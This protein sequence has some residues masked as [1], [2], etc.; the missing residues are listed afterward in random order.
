LRVRVDNLQVRVT[1]LPF[2]APEAEPLLKPHI[3]T[4]CGIPEKDI[5]DYEVAAKSIDGRRKPPS[6][7]YSLHVELTNGASPHFAKVPEPEPFRMPENQ[8]R[9]THPIVVGSGPA[10]LL[11]G[12]LL[13][14][15]GCRPLILDRGFDV[16]TRAADIARFR[17]GRVLN[18]ESNYLLGEG[19]AGTFSDGKLYTRTRDPNIRLVLETFVRCGAPPEILY[20]KRPHIGSDRLPGMI[21]GIRREIEEMGG[22]FRFGCGVRSILMRG[23]RCTGVI[24]LSGEEIE[25]PAVLVGH[26]LGGRDLTRELVRMG[27]EMQLKGFQVGCR[28][29]HPQE[30]I[31]RNQFGL[32]K[33][34][35]FLGAAEYNF[36]SHPPNRKGISTFCMCPGGEIVP[37][38][39]FP[40]RLSTNGMSPYHRDGEFANSCLI[41]TMEPDG[42]ATPEQAF[43]FL[44]GL[45]TR[46]FELGGGDYTAPAQSAAGF[47][48]GEAKLTGAGTS[49]CFGLKAAPLNQLFPKQ[50]SAALSAALL[51]FEKICPGFM[52]RGTLV[53]VETYVSSPVRF[54]RNEHGESSLPGLFL[55]GEGAGAAGGIMSAAADG[56]KVATGMLT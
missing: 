16:A 26:G 28:I 27:L 33:R 22:T 2:D 11:A 19:G 13:A 50:E 4:F 38:T 15:A 39:T 40:G 56:L 14:A 6:L 36:V 17:A 10:G 7:I 18:P 3:A 5:L 21:A 51:H 45:E 8:N 35:A 30:L 32:R 25:A 31:D 23:G 12:W 52:N 48:R 37:S 44:A 29:E 41:S 55:A 24:T 43:E 46:A 20:L 34:P 47:V 53:G 9:L 1:D 49:Y 42:F 54:L